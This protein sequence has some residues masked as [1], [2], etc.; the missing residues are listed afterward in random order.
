MMLSADDYQ[1][2]LL[3]ET[4]EKLVAPVLKDGEEKYRNGEKER[5]LSTIVLCVFFEMPVPAWARWALWDVYTRKPKSWDDA[6]GRPVPKGESAGAA[7]K[8]Q[9][10]GYH[11]VLDV[12][13]AARPI[14]ERL[15]R[16]VGKRYNVS[17]GT[18][19]R[20]YYSYWNRDFA[21]LVT[22]LM[23]KIHRETAAAGVDVYKWMQEGGDEELAK[24]V[25][26]EF[27]KS[28]ERLRNSKSGR[29]QRTSQK[30]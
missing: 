5:L 18:A 30:S 23:E 1:K 8:R 7:R 10:L 17:G 24:F 15:F 29:K 16:E 14:D 20:I 12:A 13:K 28:R 26:D 22:E 4:A 19:S 3:A 6:F 21:L 9:E 25:A 2:K 11:I 27:R